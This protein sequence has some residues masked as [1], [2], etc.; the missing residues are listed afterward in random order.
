MLGRG[1][2]A[3]VPSSKTGNGNYTKLGPLGKSGKNIV[4]GST[5]KLR[6]KKNGDVA[7]EAKRSTTLANYLAKGKQLN[8][9]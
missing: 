4:G 9:N 5:R 8:E 7:R 1:G 6:Y 3:K 2:R